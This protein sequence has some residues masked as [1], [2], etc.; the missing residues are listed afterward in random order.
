LGQNS[1]KCEVIGSIHKQSSGLLGQYGKEGGLRGRVNWW[2]M[3][4]IFWNHGS[5]HHL[6]DGN[7][8]IDAHILE[9]FSRVLLSINYM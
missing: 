5:I 4:K 7:C 6:E 2:E 9:N 3:G 8:F 1:R